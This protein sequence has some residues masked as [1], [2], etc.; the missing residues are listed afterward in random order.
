M[1]SIL[2]RRS[3]PQSAAVAPPAGARPA[4]C[5]QPDGAARHGILDHPGLPQAAETRQDGRESHVHTE[6]EHVF[7]S[8]KTDQAK[9]A[10]ATGA[11]TV[12]DAT[13]DAAERAAEAAEAVKATA[14]AA[15]KQTAEAA[16]ALAP[17]VEE[18][19]VMAA[20]A[21]E[22]VREKAEEAMEELA[23]KM[24]QAKDTFVEDVLPKVMA[25]LAAIAA[26][27]AAAKAQASDAAERAPEAYA[28][29]KGEAEVKS[30]G[31]KGKWILLL[32]GI[33]AG[34]AVMAY[35]RSNERPDPWAT[36]GS[37][38]PPR[39]TGQKVDD[40][41]DA[42]KEKATDVKEAA[43]EKA[44]EAKESVSDAA[45]AKKAAPPEKAT[46]AKKATSSSSSSSSS[47][48]P[49][50]SGTSEGADLSTPNLDEGDDATGGDS[51]K[52]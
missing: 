37:Y 8:S 10:V 30:G 35:R 14:K 28:V 9:D 45:T 25:S 43:T 12:S 17:K 50:T 23:P 39:T 31:G 1:R 24:E 2:S 20:D 34:A 32:G 18:A 3:A 49:A 5:P 52:T 7:R 33:A 36:A 51:E 26:S 40:A 41:I 15:K 29:L 6:E 4:E 19:R 21:A 44:A 22:L 47:E 11:D 16:D 46:P 13:Q 38:T 48:V 42:A 27:A